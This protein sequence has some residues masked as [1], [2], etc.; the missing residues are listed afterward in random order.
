MT[1]TPY[2]HSGSTSDSFSTATS[3]QLS[4]PIAN[5]ESNYVERVTAGFVFGRTDVQVVLAIGQSY[6][7]MT[8]DEA[9]K[10]ADLLLHLTAEEE[11]KPMPR[12]RK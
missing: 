7:Y 11:P 1:Y 2:K 8:T 9:E 6:I 12:A 5:N 10:V 4:K 3:T